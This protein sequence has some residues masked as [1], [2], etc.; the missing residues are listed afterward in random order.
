[1][2]SDGYIYGE[3]LI[4]ARQ[5]RGL[6][7][8]ALAQRGYL[9]SADIRKLEKTTAPNRI[10]VSRQTLMQL[11]ML[12]QFPERFF[13]KQPPKFKWEPCF[14]STSRCICGN[15]PT[16]LCDYEFTMRDR[17]AAD[18]IGQTCDAELCSA[19]ATSK[20]GKDYCEAH[21]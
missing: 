15:V 3:R 6:T 12:L 21:L 13:Y 4:Q 16:L 10:Q 18:R 8:H 11:C 7:R 20:N 5:I 9:R 17:V 2:F 1:M 14:C 19:C